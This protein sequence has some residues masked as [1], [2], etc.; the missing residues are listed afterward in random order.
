MKGIDGDYKLSELLSGRGG[1][2]DAVVNVPTV[3]FRIKA[4]VLPGLKKWCLI[5][6]KRRFS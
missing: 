5:K 1:N 6:P 3:K 4:M 2:T